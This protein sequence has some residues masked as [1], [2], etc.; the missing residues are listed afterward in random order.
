MAKA[1]LEQ[2]VTDLGLTIRADF[3]PYSQSRNF[4]KDAALSA[5]SLNWHVTLECKGQ[6]ILTTDY[7]AG[8]GH[9]PAYKASVRELGNANSL[10]RAEAIEAQIERGKYGL[11]KKILPDTLDVLYSLVQD[12]SVLDH[13]SFESWAS[14][15]G[16]DP[17]SRKAESIYKD[18]MTIALALRNKLGEDVFRVLQHAIEEY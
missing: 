12:A 4:H 15:Y 16:Y 10:M 11:S 8:I 6:W 7:S 18:C 5:R 9:C 14:E 13:P 3:V 17:D 1:E 2:V